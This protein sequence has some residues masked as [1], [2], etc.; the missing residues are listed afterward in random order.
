[1]HAG[2]GW[3]V[4][5]VVVALC[6]SCSEPPRGGPRLPTF[7]LTGI[8]FVD[9]VPAEGVTVECFPKP[10][11]KFRRVISGRTNADGQFSISTYEQGD[12]I[13]EGE[14][15][16]TFKWEKAA[17]F[18]KAKD[19]LKGRYANPKTSKFTITV[20]KGEQADLGRIDLTIGDSQKK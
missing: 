17:G 9:G 16:L 13:P 10:G 15:T 2:H 4:A 8:V 14:Y 12:G 6:G 3:W 1:M 7:P 11:G 5:T 19:R 18:A 20:K